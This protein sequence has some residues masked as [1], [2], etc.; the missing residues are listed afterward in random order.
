MADF[1]QSIKLSLFLGFDLLAVRVDFAPLCIM[2]G[3]S[4][5]WIVFLEFKKFLLYRK[6]LN[7]PC[8]FFSNLLIKK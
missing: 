3:I 5:P 2:I 8:T 4:I 1:I 7:I 6:N